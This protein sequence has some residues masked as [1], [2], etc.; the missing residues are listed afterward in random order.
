MN[1]VK[2][3]GAVVAGFVTVA[4]LSI[5]TDAALE[6]VGVFPSPVD[7]VFATW[8]LV[9]ALVYRSL[10]TFLGGYITGRF[11]PSNQ[12]VYVAVLGV[13]GTIGALGGVLAGWDLPD[14][15]YPITLAVTGFPLVWWGGYV[16]VRQMQRRV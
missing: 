11:A 6:W 10:Y 3:I 15:W 12:G 5:G 14:Q 9:V 7:S 2:G 16:A 13:F 8:M 4:A 1:M